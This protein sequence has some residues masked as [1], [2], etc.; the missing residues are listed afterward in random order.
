ML[1]QY[2]HYI[3]IVLSLSILLFLIF[4]ESYISMHQTDNTV[5]TFIANYRQQLMA[6]SAVCSAGLYYY[7]FYKGSDGHEA[8]SMEVKLPSYDESMSH[9]MSTSVTE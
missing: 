1:Q 6:L 2:S 3:P 7:C 8:P 4:G 9:S 5:M